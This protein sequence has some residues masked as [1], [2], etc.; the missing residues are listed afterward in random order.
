MPVTPYTRNDRL[1]SFLK[2]CASEFLTDQTRPGVLT[3]VTNIALSKDLKQGTIFFTVF[4]EADEK[5]ALHSI[6]K[7]TH[8]FYGYL[9]A[10][11][12]IKHIPLFVFSID[13]GEKNRQRIEELL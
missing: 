9:K 6:E 7:K 5:E 1:K 8:E 11:I 12:K 13:K 10:H 2:K 3:T 4:P